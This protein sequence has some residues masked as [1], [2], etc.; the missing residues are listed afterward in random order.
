MSARA[1]TWPDNQR[2]FHCQR[3]SNDGAH[4]LIFLFHIATLFVKGCVKH[5]KKRVSAAHSPR[6]PSQRRRTYIGIAAV[7]DGLVA[8]IVLTDVREGLDD[9]LTELLALLALVDGNVLNVTDATETAEELAFDEDATDANDAVAGVVDEDEG[10]V[11][12]G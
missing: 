1:R 11:C 12:S 8:P 2:H 7:Q 5:K 3:H 4:H 6:R 9:A 10:V